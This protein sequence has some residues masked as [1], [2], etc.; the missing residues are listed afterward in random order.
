[1]AAAI[2]RLATRRMIQGHIPGIRFRNVH[3]AVLHRRLETRR[4]SFPAWVLAY[5][6][7]DRLFRTVI[8]GQDAGCIVGDAPYSKLK[9]AA[10]IAAGAL[11]VMA[12]GCLQLI[13]LF[14]LP[15]RNRYTR[16]SGR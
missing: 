7:R 9:I 3:T 14:N 8:S 10:A 12:V 1:V 16:H 15:G 4:C 11:A 13:G 5:R 6:Y 2:D